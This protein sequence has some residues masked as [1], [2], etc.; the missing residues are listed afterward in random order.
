MWRD[1]FV[2]LAF[3]IEKSHVSYS[4]IS[5]N[6]QY[7]FG[8]YDHAIL[9][10]VLYIYIYV[11]IYIVS[12][13]VVLRFNFLSLFSTI[14]RFIWRCMKVLNSQNWYVFFIVFD[15]CIVLQESTEP[16]YGNMHRIFILLQ[17][18]ILF[19]IRVL[20]YLIF[21]EY[22]YNTH[23]SHFFNSTAFFRP[24]HSR[25]AVMFYHSI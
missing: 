5:K 20:Y 23:I 21:F 16:F 10:E 11:Y 25:I 9:L 22:H 1:R 4:G 8:K 24:P 19:K 15:M 17:L 12:V 2:I 3:S 7:C 14:T 6:E 18:L 13:I